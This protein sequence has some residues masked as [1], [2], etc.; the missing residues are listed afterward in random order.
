MTSTVLVTGG[1]GYIAAFL[2]RQ[3]AEAGWTVHTTIRNLAGEAKARE[4]LGIPGEPVTFFAAELMNDAGWAEAMAGCTHVAHV[5]SPF[6]VGVPKSED[7]LIVPAREGALRALRFARDAGVKRFVLTSSAAAVAY[8]HPAGKTEFTEDDWTDITAPGVQPYVKSKTIA[9]RA[10]REWVAREGGGIEFCSVNPVAVLGPVLGDDF[11]A[12][13]EIAKQLLEG[14]I[15]ALPDVGFCLVDV[16]DVADLH[17]RALI[18]P[19]DKVRNG[20]F[21]ASAGPFYK[22]ADLAR[23]VR[24]RLGDQARKVPTRRMPNFMVRLLARFVPDLRQLVGELGR[25]RS[26]SGQHARDALGWAPRS[27][28]DTIE[29]TARSLIERG[30][31]AV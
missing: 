21:I 27:P 6:P 23:V 13:I 7:D 29:D 20:R 17:V 25:T 24:A 22:F 5:A 3:L 26:T 14:K 8:G 16:R 12:S 28:D 4:R 10:A 15:P 19:A 1:S 9:E 18:A 2:I 30:L 11:A 31:V